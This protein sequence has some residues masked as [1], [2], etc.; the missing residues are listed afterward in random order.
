[1]GELNFHDQVWF[2]AIRE[3]LKYQ[4]RKGTSDGDGVLDSLIRLGLIDKNEDLVGLAYQQC[5]RYSAV[6][7][8]RLTGHTHMLE[9]NVSTFPLGS[10]QRD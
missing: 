6:L 3:H 7:A 5:M 1:M 9:H 10:S 4:D 2:N 8:G